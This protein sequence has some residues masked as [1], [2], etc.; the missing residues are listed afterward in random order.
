M[1]FNMCAGDVS[2]S[3]TIKCSCALKLII[4]LIKLCHVINI[5]CANLSFFSHVRLCD[6]MDCSLP[7]S[8]VHGILQ[9]RILEWVAIPFSRGSSPYLLH[10]RQAL[11]PLSHLGSPSSGSLASN[12]QRLEMCSEKAMATHSSALAWKIPWT[13]EPC[14]LQSMGLQQSRIH[15]WSDL[16]AAA[17]EMCW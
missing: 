13:E 11:Y 1:H 8:S 5:S 3:N 10:C 17:A 12:F 9:A 14:R 6:P 2:T 7:G 15:D 16:A 4:S